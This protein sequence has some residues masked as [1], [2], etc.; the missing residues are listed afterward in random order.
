MMGNILPR[1]ITN[2]L[3]RV[4][5]TGSTYLGRLIRPTRYARPKPDTVFNDMVWYFWWNMQF[6]LKFTKVSLE[7]FDDGVT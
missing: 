5:N 4:P 6:L 2:R 1:S 7:T 3:G